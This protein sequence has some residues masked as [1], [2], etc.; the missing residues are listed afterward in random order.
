MRNGDAR[1]SCGQINIREC[2]NG[3]L[4]PGWTADQLERLAVLWDRWHLN[5]MNACCEH[6]RA[7]GWLEQ[8]REIVT[9]YNWSLNTETLI[10]KQGL[11]KECKQRLHKGEAVQL[12]GEELEIYNLE[13][14]V[15]TDPQPSGKYAHLYG[16]PSAGLAGIVNPTFTKALGWL[17]PSEHPRGILCK[18]CPECGYKYGSAWLKEEVP[19]AVLEELRSFPE[20]E[21]TPAWV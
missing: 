18:E 10:R 5:D 21:L 16:P 15:T 19:A 17:K 3:E 4:S 8:A 7:A 20:S 1:G 6:Q 11:E 13:S 2:V 12:V 9:F 14:L